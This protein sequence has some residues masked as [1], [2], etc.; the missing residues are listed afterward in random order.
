MMTKMMQQITD[1]IGIELDDA[2]KQKEAFKE[3]QR[4]AHPSKK[5]PLP[6]KIKQETEDAGGM[7]NWSKKKQAEHKS[8]II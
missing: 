3:F 1:K 8:K 4:T 2:L 5:R 7:K 6:D